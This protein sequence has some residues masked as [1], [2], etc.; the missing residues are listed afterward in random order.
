MRA[1]NPGGARG[2]RRLAIVVVSVLGLLAAGPVAG[3][4]ADLGFQDQSFSGAST[5]TGTKRAESVLWW[6]DGSWWAVMWDV[7]SQ[8]FHIFRLDAGTQRWIDTG[9]WVDTRSNTQSDVLWDGSKLYV[10]SHRVASDGTAAAPGY[11]S[12]L[13]R[14]SY[15]PSTKTYSRD[16]GFPVR[17]ND[18]KTE[19][20][21]IDKDSTGKIW[22][23]WQQDNQIFVNRTVGSDRTWGAP[24]A[25]PVP[26][27]NVTVD[28]NSAVVSFAGSRIGVMW[29][30]QTSTKNAMY[31]AVHNDGDADSTWTGTRTALQGPRSADDHMNL[32]SLQVDDSGRVFAAVKTSFTTS[33]SPLIE[34]LVRDRPSGNWARYPVALVADCPNRPIVIIDEANNV[35]HVYAT[36]PGPPSYSCNSSGGAIYEKVSPLSNLSFP[37]GRGTPVMQ[38]DD[39]PYIHNVSTSKQNVTNATGIALL[40]VNNRTKTYW[41]SFQA[42]P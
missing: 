5:P 3:A 32:K 30:N 36:Y 21:V 37:T 12:W 13:Y 42:L 7:V 17:I 28:D 29:S 14:F 4:R 40:A 26:D 39:S 18:Y 38:D 24:F 19:T 25:L 27:T 6:N 9:V 23:T 22:A 11:A 1:G 41:H 33:S 15:N 8:D 35:V 31:F 16:S 34:L 20:L 2:T 10:A